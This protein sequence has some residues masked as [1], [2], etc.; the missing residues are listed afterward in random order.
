VFD[1]WAA[2]AFHAEADPDEADADGDEPVAAV[3]WRGRTYDVFE[4][5]D[6]RRAE[7]LIRVEY[8]YRARGGA[9]AYVDRIEHRYLL[10]GQVPGLAAAAGL[11]VAGAWGG[12]RG[13]PL[14]RDSEHLAYLLRAE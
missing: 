12:L 2:D 1:A 10:T 11:R 4:T 8:L 13:E 9:D 7:Q 3:S 6:W 14:R 5:S